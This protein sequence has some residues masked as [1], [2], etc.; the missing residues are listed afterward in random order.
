LRR[1]TLVVVDGAGEPLGMTAPFAVKTP[2][3]QD[4]EPV[5]AAHP[6]VV[7][8]R[9]LRA[10]PAP[11]SN[12]GGEVTYL[13]QADPQ[14]PDLEPV[15][16]DLLTVIRTKDPRRVPWAHPG[17]PQADLEWAAG[18]V[19]LSGSPQQMRSWN[20]S[21]IWRLSTADGDVWLKCVPPMFGHEPAVIRFWGPDAPVPR[22]I[23]ASGHRMLLAGLEGRDGYDAN[24]SQFAAIIDVLVGLQAGHAD[25]LPSLRPVLPDWGFPSLRER[26]SAARA[27]RLDRW[28]ALSA[29]LDDRWDSLIAAIDEC[30]LGPTLFHGD[31]HP[32][33]ARIGLAAPVLFDWGDSGW[34]HPLLDLAVLERYDLYGE[35]GLCRHWLERWGAAVPGSDPA[36][37]WDL[38]R[39]VALA[40][41]AAVFRMFVDAIE[42][43]EAVYHLGDIDP[44]LDQAEAALQR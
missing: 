24:R 32:G 20:L 4:L 16:P 41:A 28:P 5:L 15:S 34:G 3:W 1:V 37:A 12:A 17:G 23:A 2:W 26:I 10:R 31:L 40:R 43:T 19:E 33:N 14:P 30:G 11:G 13:V 38:L 42:E 27:G 7:V 44:A 8:L 29:L 6:G 21:S 36:R 39:P 35:Y 18:L 22:L 25:R 9:L